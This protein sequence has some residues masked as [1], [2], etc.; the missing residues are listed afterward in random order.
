MFR[1]EV[2]DVSRSLADRS[3]CITQSRVFALTPIALESGAAFMFCARGQRTQHC[4]VGVR[5]VAGKRGL[6]Q[7]CRR[8]CHQRVD[9]RLQAF[10]TIG[11]ACLGRLIGRDLPVRT[12]AAFENT[13]E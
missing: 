2:S 4:H 6:F 11:A 13:S 5:R 1:T 9:Y 3:F 7:P 10:I 8:F 12:G